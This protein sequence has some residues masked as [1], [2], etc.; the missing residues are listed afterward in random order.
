MLGSRSSSAVTEHLRC[1]GHEARPAGNTQVPEPRLALG[2]R[3]HPKIRDIFANIFFRGC[4]FSL[5]N[6]SEAVCGRR[7]KTRIRFSS[8]CP[9]TAL[10]PGLS[11]TFSMCCPHQ[12]SVLLVAGRAELA[13]EQKARPDDHSRGACRQ[14]GLRQAHGS[15]VT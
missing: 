12:W 13:E 3:T 7:S 10:G 9:H 8:N 15:E 5:S 1:S 11:A 14:D 6:P 2:G 4:S